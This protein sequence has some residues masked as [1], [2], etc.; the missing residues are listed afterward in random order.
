[1]T[2]TISQYYDLVNLQVAAEAF[3]VDDETKKI[4]EG[5]KLSEALTIGNE[6]ATKFTKDSADAFVD[7]FEVVAQLPNTD[8]GFSGT[9][10]KALVDDPQAGLVKDQYF[11]VFRSTEFVD[12]YIRDS[13][14]S[15]QSIKNNGWAFGQIC[16]ME[17]W[18]QEL[19]NSGDLPQGADLTVVGYSLGGHLANAFRQLRMEAGDPDIPT[20]TFNG[21]GTGTLEDGHTLKETLDLFRSVWKTGVVPEEI[22]NSDDFV[23]KLTLSLKNVDWLTPK[24]TELL[25]NALDPG[26]LMREIA[27]ERVAALRA[28]SEEIAKFVPKPGSD[29]HPKIPPESEN[30]FV[31]NINIHLA[32]LA[33]GFWTGGAFFA[34]TIH[35]L[36]KSAIPFSINSPILQEAASSSCQRAVSTIPTNNRKSSSKTSL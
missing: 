1:M 26:N 22:L 25:A 7:K 31:R 4:K 35:L 20:Y 28:R 33:A 13:E 30:A 21:A 3:L 12:D 2:S 10:F 23:E 17:D 27:E 19:R 9:L 11:M 8:T 16:D 5:D 32:E 36:T 18:Y 6:H 14:G 15:N 34:T 24:I 29:V